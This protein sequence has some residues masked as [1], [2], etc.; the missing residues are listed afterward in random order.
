MEAGQ[1]AVDLGF[2][3]GVGLRALLATSAGRISGV[4]SS[5]D[6][7]AAGRKR[8]AGEP[9]V[10]LVKGSAADLPFA[11]ASVD[12]LLTVH[13]L[14]FWPDPA[15]GMAEAAR[16]LAPGGRL[17]VAIQPREVMEGD[18]LHD[19]GFTLYGASELRALLAGADFASVDVREGDGE[20][21]GLAT[22]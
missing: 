2:G 10:E 18:P 19:H 4:E 7:L 13:T 11:D 6:A 5:D 12:R 16:V 1:H 20:L 14:Y 3:G 15:A 17:C 9:R 22:R 8:F 21:F